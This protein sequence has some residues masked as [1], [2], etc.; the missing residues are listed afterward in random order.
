[1]HLMFYL[2]FIKQMHTQGFACVTHLSKYIIIINLFSQ[3]LYGIGNIIF[4]K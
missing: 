3:Q 2:Y 4:H 1:M